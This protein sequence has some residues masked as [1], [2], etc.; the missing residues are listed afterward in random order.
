MASKV[1]VLLIALEA[2]VAAH[3]AQTLVDQLERLSVL[4]EKSLLTAEQYEAAKDAII[5]GGDGGMEKRPAATIMAA[6]IARRTSSTINENAAASVDD[7]SFWA[8]AENA[9]L[10]LGPSADVD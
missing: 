3:G 4:F 2:A 7:V 8:K 5:L 1:V 6:A 9:K 10:A